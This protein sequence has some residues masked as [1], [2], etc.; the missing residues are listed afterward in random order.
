MAKGLITDAL[1]LVVGLD[2]T[3][4][5]V[6]GKDLE[7]QRLPQSFEIR[8]S[9]INATWSVQAIASIMREQIIIPLGALKAA[10]ERSVKS[11]APFLSLIQ[12][13]HA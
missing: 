6:I 7:V 8:G 10:P 1:C 3:S 9:Q 13:L 12:T 11:L 2:V 4:V 5:P